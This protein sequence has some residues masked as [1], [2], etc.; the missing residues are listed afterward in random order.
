MRHNARKLPAVLL[1]ALVCTVCFGAARHKP[2][3]VTAQE[4]EEFRNRFAHVKRALTEAGVKVAQVTEQAVVS[5]RRPRR[6]SCVVEVLAV[7]SQVLTTTFNRRTGELI[8]VNNRALSARRQAESEKGVTYPFTLTEEAA[9]KQIHVYYRALLGTEPPSSGV[10]LD[11]SFQKFKRMARGV[12][13]NGRLFETW[14]R[15]FK[16]YPFHDDK[17]ILRVSAV[18][19][20]FLQFHRVYDCNE[21]ASV[22]MKVTEEDAPRLAMEA[23]TRELTKRATYDPAA[24]ITYD[25]EGI[26]ITS[27]AERERVL[28]ERREAARE[29]T[30]QYKAFIDTE[31]ETLLP[32]ALMIVHPNVEFQDSKPRS[33]LPDTDRPTRLAW[34]MAVFLAEDVPHGEPPKR[35]GR[36]GLIAEVWIDA[37][38]EAILGGVIQFGSSEIAMRDDYTWMRQFSSTPEAPAPK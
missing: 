9:T 16:E 14:P 35:E 38:D 19:G 37:E 25:S 15:L 6:T 2:R 20:A 11:Q 27:K 33:E 24:V 17:D 22:T 7:G 32:P 28:A 10:F 36:F 12:P 1:C 30:D 23:I 3:F 26:L 13:A 5:P 18:D 8:Y 34:V 4:V 21:P 31:P 29:E